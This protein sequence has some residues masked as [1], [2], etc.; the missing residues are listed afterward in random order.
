L[1]VWLPAVAGGGIKPTSCCRL[2]GR[3]E[4]RHYPQQFGRIG[5]TRHGVSPTPETLILDPIVMAQKGVLE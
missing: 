3:P 5:A 1:T 2:A 4:S